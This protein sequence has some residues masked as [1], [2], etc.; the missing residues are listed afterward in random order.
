MRI[1]LFLFILILSGCAQKGHVYKHISPKEMLKLCFIGDTGTGLP[2]QEKVTRMLEMEKCNSI[3]FVGDIIYPKGIMSDSDSGFYKKFFNYY[4]PLTDKEPYPRLYMVMGN[5]DH[6][7]SVDAWEEV[8]KKHEKIIFPSPWY[9]V[10]VNDLC[11][12]HLDTDYYTHMWDFSNGRNQVKWLKKVEKRDMKDCVKRIAITH[13][14]Y[15]S[16]GP[17][18]VEST[19]KIKDFLE[20]NIIGK[21][22]FLIAGHEHILSDEGVVKGTHLLIS[23]AGGKPEK[24][25]P[26]GFLVLNWNL[27]TK[28]MNYEFRKLPE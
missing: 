22:D 23:G 25:Y 27:K 3:H 9:L 17:K 13:H 6:E 11:L 18:H 24:N 16:S 21:Y 1:T 19:G 5:H 26:G 28:E 12:V 4:Y 2:V 10:K 20:D 8:A 14:P 7:G 15:L